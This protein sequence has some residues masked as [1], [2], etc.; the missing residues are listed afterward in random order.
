MRAIIA[1][2][3]RQSHLLVWLG[4]LLSAVLAALYWAWSR[5][6]V[7]SIQDQRDL[8]GFMALLLLLT[9]GVMILVATAGLFSSETGRGTL[10]FLLGLP[11][12]R[13]RI[14]LA[15]AIAGLGIALSSA[16]LLIVPIAIVLPQVMREIDLRPYLL[17]I[18]TGVLLL[19]SIAFFCTTVFQRGISVLLVTVIIF[20]AV[21][22]LAAVFLS[23][24][25]PI[26][27]YDDQL[28]FTLIALF[29]VPGFLLASL[30]MFSR[31]E[32]LMT[33]RKWWLAIG[34][35]LVLIAASLLIAAG[36][37]HWVYRYQRSRVRG[38]RVEEIPTRGAAA[39]LTALGSPSPYTRT[40]GEGWTH[41]D[42]TH[43]RS[44]NMVALDLK[45]GRELM[46][47]AMRGGGWQPNPVVSSDGG[48]LAELDPGWLGLNS[49]R[50]AIWDLRTRRRTYVG[51]PA[52][53]R[54]A[55][56]GEKSEIRWSPKGD[57][58]AIP[59]VSYGAVL[60]GA[61]P[62]ERMS[63]H[64]EGHSVL[65]MRPDG[66]ERFEL[67]LWEEPEILDRAKWVAARRQWIVEWAWAPDGTSLYT[68][69]GDGAVSRVRIP[70]GEVEKVWSG[71]IPGV[72]LPEGYQWGFGQLSVSPDG[73]WIEISAGASAVSGKADTQ[74]KPAVS[75]VISADGSHARTVANRVFPGAIWSSDSSILYLVNVN[76]GDLAAYR[77]RAGDEKAMHVAVPPKIR[78]MRAEAIGNGRLLIWGDRQTHLVDEQGRFTAPRSELLRL[79]P[80]DHE[81][82]GV[83]AQGRLIVRN[84]GAGVGLLSAYDFSTDTLTPIYP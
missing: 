43:Y 8:D 70:G 38:L 6:Y 22:L 13:G 67:K 79:L 18:A 53:S 30:F 15:K 83:D 26:L 71:S 50:I 36:A 14:W 84:A 54:H 58:L 4:F 51:A 39:V 42:Y 63:P 57:W 31:G 77:W 16:L 82:V 40:S 1:K 65:V 28:D 62:N 19:F 32:L 41:S 66:S 37:T 69:R 56:L 64:R 35:L 59:I 49:D 2:E 80:K 3:F 61:G 17:D 47:F 75:L 52:E 10:A 27:G 48:H 25:G 21:M 60:K 11:I 72:A 81:L 24:N 9:T 46:V 44:Q 29:L 23:L 55:I 76:G 74:L 12:S 33:R 20:G 73:R 5:N 7:K 34:S 68:L 45:T 78:A